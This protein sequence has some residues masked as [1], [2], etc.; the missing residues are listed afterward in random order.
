MLG[1]L[2]LWAAW[3]WPVGKGYEY[4]TIAEMRRK[5]K[6]Y[7]SAG[8]FGVHQWLFGVR[9][10]VF[11]LALVGFWTF[12]FIFRETTAVK[13][14]FGILLGLLLVEWSGHSIREALREVRDGWRAS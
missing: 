13:V 10:G 4:L 8:V 12:L 9:L 7:G 6:A 2:A 1:M 3:V 11:V 5:T 14:F